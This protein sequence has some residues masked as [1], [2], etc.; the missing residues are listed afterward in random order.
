VGEDLPAGVERIDLNAEHKRI[1]SEIDELTDK[2]A[3]MNPETDQYDT[4]DG[5]SSRLDTHRRGTEWARDNWD[6]DAIVIRSLSF[7]DDARLDEHTNSAAERRLW[8]IAIGTVEGPYLEH[9]GHAYPEVAMDA[10][11]ETV[12]TIDSPVVPI[13]VGRW[14][15]DRIDEVSTVGNLTGDGSYAT[16]LA[17]KRAETSTET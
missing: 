5:R 17:A 3:E 4:L 6:V 12:A 2:L 13:A 8:Q 11:G 1:V 7:G 9:D 16:S 14:L 15:Q 10:V